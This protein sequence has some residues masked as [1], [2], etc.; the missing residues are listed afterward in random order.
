[1]SIYAV[2]SL[3]PSA[4]LP[5]E[6]LA[7]G[8]SSGSFSSYS[9][10]QTSATP[11]SGQ[12]WQSGA[13]MSGV[14]PRFLAVLTDIQSGNP[15]GAQATPATASSDSGMTSQNSGSAAGT[16]VQYYHRSTG[17]NNTTASSSI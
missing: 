14:T 12:A 13:Y 17:G 16:S 10:A 11:S 3:S 1:M 2:A 15:Q 7:R 6:L 8:D 5:Q 9:A 4:R